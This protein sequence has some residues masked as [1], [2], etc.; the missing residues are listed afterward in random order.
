MLGNKYNLTGENKVNRM[1]LKMEI[2]L[3]F[4]SSIIKL[5]L[6]GIV[7]QFYWSIF[8]DK[9]LTTFLKIGERI[10]LTFLV[11]NF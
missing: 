11:K 5:T 3:L 4:L 8:L 7:E 2:H 1:M 6:G 9:A 10:Y